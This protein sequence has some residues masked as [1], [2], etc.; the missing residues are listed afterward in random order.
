M[1][2]IKKKKVPIEVF[3]ELSTIV[4]TRFKEKKITREDIEKE[5]ETVK[6][7]R[8]ITLKFSYRKVFI[9]V[10]KLIGLWHLNQKPRL[11]LRIRLNGIGIKG[12][13]FI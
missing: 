4:S 8:W 3:E 5:I 11:K 1:A 7:G 13:L 12:F 9:L 10:I 6:K 2:L